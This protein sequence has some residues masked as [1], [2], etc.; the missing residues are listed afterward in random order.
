MKAAKKYSR[1]LA[2][3]VWNFVMEE[4]SEGCLQAQK[5]CSRMK[6]EDEEGWGDD[7][8]WRQRSGWHLKRAR[9]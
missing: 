2:Q 1:I 7:P 5:T 4:Q 3:K 9:A 6:G 8:E